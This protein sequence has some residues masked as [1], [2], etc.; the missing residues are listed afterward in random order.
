LDPGAKIP[1]NDATKTPIADFGKVYFGYT[2][3]GD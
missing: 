1:P 2:S 3:L